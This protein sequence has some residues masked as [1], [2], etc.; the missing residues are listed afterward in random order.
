MGKKPS[1]ANPNSG[2]EELHAAARSG[3][4]K[5]VQ[6]ICNANPLAVNSRDRHSRTPLHLAAWSGHSEV[7]DYLCKNKADVG[8]AAMDDMGA[9]HFAAQKG[10][11]EVVKTLVVSGVSV[12]SSNRKGMTALHYAAQGSNLELVKY[13][14]KKGANK[15]LKNK[16][17]NT[18]VDL[19]SSEEIRKILVEYESSSGKVA[20]NG[21]E[22]GEN[23]ETKISSRDKVEGSDSNADLHGDETAEE[24]KDGILKRKVEEETKENQTVAKKSK[25]ALNHLLAADDTQEEEEV[26]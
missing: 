19:A 18:A 1:A 7:V 11:L 3:D 24:D 17:G 22:K 21:K 23:A 16:A 10:H 14:L 15:H 13:L 25:V 4:L 8:A 5:A 9:I 20:L 12:K 6:A 26:E 2:N